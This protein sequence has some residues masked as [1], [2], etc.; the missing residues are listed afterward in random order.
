MLSILIHF[1]VKRLSK[2]F[3]ATVISI[4]LN[5]I[6]CGIYL[7]CIWIA[8]VA[9]EDKFQVK[10]KLWRAG[11][12][13]FMAF[14]IVLWFTFLSQLI[15][16]FLSVSKLMVVVHPIDT[17][18]KKLTFTCKSVLLLYMLSFISALLITFLIKIT[19]KALT[20]SLYLPFV[21]P[22]GSIIL[23]KSVTWFVAITQTVTS[24][25]I[26]VMYI[27]LGKFFKK[28]K[29]VFRRSKSMETLLMI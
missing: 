3:S 15:L 4:N 16:I 11:P 18:F 9:L 28:S 21:D 27:L 8:D 7:A 25:N 6:L 10:E 22:T 13:C 19:Y 20:I 12:L 24:I 2:P 17:M 23:I 1:L 26:M 29:R 5:N 14:T